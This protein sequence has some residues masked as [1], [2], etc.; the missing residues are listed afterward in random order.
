MK[1]IDVRRNECSSMKSRFTMNKCNFGDQWG[2]GSRI[3][4]NLFIRDTIQY[5][6]RHPPAYKNESF[7]WFS[8][9]ETNN[10]ATEETTDKILL[11]WWPGK[12]RRRMII[13][14]RGLVR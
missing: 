13:L 7:F 14:V 9:W 12:T 8:R 6:L 4:R 3:G 10:T 5:I 2:Q 1:V 11:V